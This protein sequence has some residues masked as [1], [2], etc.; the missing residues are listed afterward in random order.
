[1]GFN[2]ETFMLT[3]EPALKLYDQIKDQPIFDYHCHLDP[4]EIFEDK[5][6]DNIVDLWLG[7]DH[8]KWRLMR[9]HG[10]SEDYITGA[11][12]KLDKFKAFARSLSRSYGNPVYHWSAMELKN[13]FG[14][15]EVLTEENAEDIY[16]RINETLK[17]KKI[18]PRKLIKDSQ[19]TFIGTTDHPLDSL[20]WHQKLADDASFETT[21]AP[22]FRPDEAFIEHR[23]FT[24]FIR[25]LSQ[26]TAVSIEEFQ[27]VINALE[28]RVA[29]FAEK[30]CKASDI[31]FTEIVFEEADKETL[32]SL[33]KTVQE[34]YQPSQLE[35]NQWQTAVFAELCRLYKQYGFVTQVHFGA[36][37]NNHSG[38]F[39][40]LGSDVGVDSLG[41]QTALAINMNRLLDHLAQQNNLPKMIWYNLNP[42][43]NIVVANTLA[44]FQTNEE[45]IKSY[46]QFGA[47]WWFA[48]TKSGMLSQM[49]ALAEQGVLANFVGML[50]DSR[51]FLSYQ[52]HDYF[53]RIL[54]SYLGQWMV[55]GEVPNDYDAIGQMAKD[56]AYHN[57]VEYFND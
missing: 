28:K 55:D 46:L 37:R 48:D 32:D 39:Q 4:K 51:S 15:D 30:G 25:R 50:T 16:Y 22:T 13:V 56:I 21:V 3:S 53:R 17:T 38:I 10:V 43:Y 5:V 1:M 29:Y 34:G 54:A 47:G 45:G 2:D 19:V 12:S 18:S 31:S 52:R 8:Y 26:V 40:Q 44:N 35:I 41:D 49:T 7:G 11:A 27:D 14:I 9:A 33:L 24:D 57:A 20:E 42:S 23:N 6:Y 36:L